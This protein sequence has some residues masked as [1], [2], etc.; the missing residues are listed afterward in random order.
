MYIY[1]CSNTIFINLLLSTKFFKFSRTDKPFSRH[2]TRPRPGKHTHTYD[3]QHWIFS[4]CSIQL[5]SNSGKSPKFPGIPGQAVA[6]LNKHKA[7]PR[8]TFIAIKCFLI[9]GRWP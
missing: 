1:F 2:P 3:I 4:L 5:E 6:A 7:R 9:S 8:D